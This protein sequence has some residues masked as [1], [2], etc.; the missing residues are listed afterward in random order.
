MALQREN[1]VSLQS[2][3]AAS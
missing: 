1:V 3:F 2:T